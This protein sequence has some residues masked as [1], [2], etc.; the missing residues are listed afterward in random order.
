M[1][2]AEQ[3]AVAWWLRG[4]T[5]QTLWA[6]L[7]RSRHLVRFEREVLTTDD[8]DDLVLDHA[9]GPA[10]L[11]PHSPVARPR[12]E[13]A[14]AAHA[15]A[16][17]AG[18]ARRVALHGAQLPLLRARSGAALASAA[19]TG[20]R[21]SITRAT[22]PISTSWCARWP[23]AS[24]RCPSTRWGFRWGETCCSSGWGRRA[25]GSAIRAAATISVPYDLAAAS[26]YLER[27]GRAPLHLPLPAAAQAEGARRAGAVSAR[28]G[29]PRRRPH[30]APRGRS[31]SSISGSPRR[32]TGSPA[33]RT[34]TQRASSLGY[35]SRIA[36]PTLC[37]SSEDDPF[38]PAESVARARAAASADGHLRGDPLGRSHRLRLRPLA[39]AAALLGRG[40]EHRLAGRDPGATS[41][42]R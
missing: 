36:V 4:A 23:R 39:L 19:E 35:L 24:R 11:A 10:G 8:D 5:A 37:I 12:G 9:A 33:P 29:A 16:G 42:P 7:A 28:D 38:Y 30:R 3:P 41:A 20:G 21:A 25:S 13:R 1:P 40:A 27:A 22:P 18:G 34:T 32:C 6:R 17:G 15:G 2:G 31:P 26:R 14:L